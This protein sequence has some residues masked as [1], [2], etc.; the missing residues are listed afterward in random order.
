MLPFFSDSLFNINYFERLHKPKTGKDCMAHLFYLFYAGLYVNP[1]IGCVL[2]TWRCL[3]I[4]VFHIPSD[5]M[6][7]GTASSCGFSLIMSTSLPWN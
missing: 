4:L 6:S 3:A 5:G 7:G 1:F 2:C